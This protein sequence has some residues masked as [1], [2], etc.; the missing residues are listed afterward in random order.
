MRRVVI[1]KS[2]PE[3]EAKRKIRALGRR[4]SK[5][6][7]GLKDL[8]QELK[9]FEKKFGMST[10]EFYEKFCTGKMGDERDVI[11]WSGLYKAYMILALDRDRPKAAAR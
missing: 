4:R 3:H 6:D 2:M 9:R 8:V 11:I 7:D 1:T 10:V 5:K